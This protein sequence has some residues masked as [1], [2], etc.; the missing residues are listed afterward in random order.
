MILQFQNVTA[1]LQAPYETGLAATDFTLNAGDLLLARVAIESVRT[2]LPDLAQGLLAPVEGTV[3]FSGQNWQTAHPD[4]VAELRGRI[5]RVFESGGWLSNLD[6][7]ENVLLSQKYHTGR[8]EQ[9]MLDEAQGLA[10]FFDLPALP[11]GR[12][13]QVARHELR[14]AQWV[15]AF[16]GKPLLIILEDPTED[17]QARWAEKLVEKSRQARDEGAAVIW[18]TSSPKEESNAA[19]KPTLKFDLRDVNMQAAQEHG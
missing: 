2:P 11:K 10:R 4:R 19:L 7:D 5:G 13:H 8:P 6:V 12:P 15:R 3:S 18:I 16:I 1:E 14:R 9:E 17:L